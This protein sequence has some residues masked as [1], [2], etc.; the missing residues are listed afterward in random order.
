MLGT[1][2]GLQCWNGV[3]W[4]KGVRVFK[5]PASMCLGKKV[6]SQGGRPGAKELEAG[7]GTYDMA[8]S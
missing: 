8:A 2:G 6:P 3:L 7:W 1:L 4:F 5:R